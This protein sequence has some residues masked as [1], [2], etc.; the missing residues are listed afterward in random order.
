MTL[1]KSIGIKLRQNIKK[2]VLRKKVIPSLFYTGGRK[3]IGDSM[4]P[5]LTYKLKGETLP[6]SN[7]LENNGPHLFTIGSILQFSTND[8]EIWGSGFISQ[9]SKF[10]SI[11]RVFHAVR[12]PMTADRIEVLTGQKIL[13]FGDP[14]LLTSKFYSPHGIQSTNIIGLIPHYAD[15]TNLLNSKIINSKGIEVIDVETD[16]IESFVNQIIKC[17]LIISSS[18]HG[19]ILAESY[20]VPSFWAKFGTDVYGDDFK[21]YDYYLSTGRNVKPLGFYTV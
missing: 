6:Y 15:K 9:N 19:I 5:W 8:C 1:I 21:F 10:K 4:V 3:N 16:D 18:L 2:F 13:N 12:G 20:G 14:A 11:P 7:P 17:K